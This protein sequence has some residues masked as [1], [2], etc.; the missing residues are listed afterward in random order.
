MPASNVQPFERRPN[1]AL[2]FEELFTAI[3]RLRTNRQSV[4]DAESFKTHV[5]NALHT[6]MQEG[7][8]RGYTP[9]D[10]SIAAYAVVAFLDE[11]ILNLKSPAF[12]NWSGQSLQQELSHKHLAGEAFFEYLRQLLARRDSVE[13]ADVLDVFYLCLLLGYRGRYALA[14]AGELTAIMNTLQDKIS[15]SRGVNVLLSPSALLPRDLPQAKT[16]DKWVK[17]LA[18]AAVLSL[19]ISVV[20]FVICK[21]S[22]VTSASALQSLAGR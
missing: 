5:R 18:F 3:V 13:L 20:M 12:A 7:H 8:A 2:A 21:I 1:L 6:A 22:L 4:A 14:D 10:V 15:R 19:I 11:S 17:R 9:D 16:P